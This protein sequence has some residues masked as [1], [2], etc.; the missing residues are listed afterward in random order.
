METKNK[1]KSFGAITEKWPQCVII[2]N[3]ITI[4]QAKEVI[5]RTDSMFVYEYGSNEREYDKCIYNII[6]RPQLDYNTTIKEYSKII[7]DINDFIKR[8]NLL[9]LR[10]L[11]NAQIAS[12]YIGGTHGWCHPNGTIFSNDNIGKWPSWDEIHDDCKDIAHAFPFLDMKVYIFN[13]EASSDEDSGEYYDY[14]RKC[15]GGFS[16]KNGRCRLLKE[17]E[18]ISPNDEK[19]IKHRSLESMLFKRI[20]NEKVQEKLEIFGDKADLDMFYRTNELFFNIEEF[21]QYFDGYF[22]L[23]K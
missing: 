17:S 15:V 4:D 19:V 23:N 21:K 16:I 1:Y 6:G 22:C 7:N 12:C 9:E 14:P 2:G 8:N 3:K 11:T 13:Q 20:D 18:Y 10:Y 5:A